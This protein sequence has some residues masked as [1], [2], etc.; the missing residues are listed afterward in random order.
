MPI[1]QISVVAGRPREKITNLIHAVTKTVAE[2]LDA[3]AE[4]IKVL[5]TEVNP[6]HWGSGG[7]TIQEKR[8]NPSS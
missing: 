2:S 6:T 5:V 7:V 3:P 4:T 8:L 1:V